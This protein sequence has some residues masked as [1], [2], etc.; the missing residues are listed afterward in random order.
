MNKSTLL[1]PFLQNCQHRI[2]A[3]LKRYLPPTSQIPQR[4]HQ[5]MHHA[6][7]NGG[8]RLRPLLV[9]ATGQAL[10][11]PIENLD[12]PAVAVELIHCYSLI[13]DDLPSMDNDDQRRGQ[14]ACHKAFDEATAILAGDALQ[15]LA[16]SCLNEIKMVQI[17]AKASGSQ[18]M[19]GGQDL[20]LAAEG[21]TLE[22]LALQYIHQL[23]TGALLEASIELGVMAAGC[24]QHSIMTH[25]KKFAQAIGLAFQIQD[26]LLDAQGNSHCL[27]KTAGL[28]AINHKVTYPSLL[29]LAETKRHLQKQYEL[30]R[31][32][33]NQLPFETHNLELLCTYIANRNH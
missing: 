1:S 14:L 11:A 17:L 4:L 27:G 15:S 32:L 13:H 31:A 18:G 5:A 24:C 19:A 9:Y 23:K 33:L 22:L 2:I 30:A 26:D 10:Q 3:Q 8:K 21:Q 6:V 7:L 29:G 20:D 12:S 25:L 16:F 28:D